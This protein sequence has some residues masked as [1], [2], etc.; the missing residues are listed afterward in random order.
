MASAGQSVASPANLEAERTL[1]INFY[2]I[3]FDKRQAQLILETYTD[4]GCCDFYKIPVRE[5]PL[6][7]IIKTPTLRVARIEKDESLS[8]PKSGHV[9]D[10]GF[11]LVSFAK[12]FFSKKSLV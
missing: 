2:R 7:H 6:Y 8:N 3:K 12:L 1:N 11:I 4:L 9:P 10:F 5:Y